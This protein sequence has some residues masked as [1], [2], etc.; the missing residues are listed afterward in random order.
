M[1]TSELPG[2]P[3]PFSRMERVVV[4]CHSFILDVRLVDVARGML[5]KICSCWTLMTS[6]K[7]RHTGRVRSMTLSASLRIVVMCSLLSCI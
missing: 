2:R 6:V 4:S 7:G 5:R 1:V 3:V